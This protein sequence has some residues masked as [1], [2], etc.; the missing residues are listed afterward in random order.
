MAHGVT[1]APAAASAQTPLTADQKKALANLHTA[2]SQFEGVFLQ[3]VMS[4]MRAT[5]PQD[6]IF[7]E[8][9]GSGQMWQSMLDDEYSQ[10]MAKSGGIGLATQMERQMRAAVLANAHNEAQSNPNGA[11][12]LGP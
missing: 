8:D 10:Q 6:S 3:M 9:S 4:A 2:A 7:G 12:R 5:V 11:K 1:A